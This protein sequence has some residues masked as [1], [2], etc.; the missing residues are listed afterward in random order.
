MV[1]DVIAALDASG[2]PASSLVLEVTET[3]LIEDLN[4]AGSTLAKLKVLGLRVAVDDF[5]TGHSSLAYLSSFPIDIIKIDK[6]FVDQVDVAVEGERMIRRSS[7]WLA[8][9]GSLPLPKAS[10]VRGKPSRCVGWGVHWH[11]ASSLPDLCPLKTWPCRTTI[12]G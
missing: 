9:L 12:S 1:R 3:G 10:N 7:T 8:R 4:P 11:R 5:G 6:S 2:L